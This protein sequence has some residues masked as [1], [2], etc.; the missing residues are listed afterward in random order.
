MATPSPAK[1][2][3]ND[4]CPCG[5]GKK[6]K[7]CCL[8]EQA[9]QYDLWSRQ[10][11]ASDALTRDMMKFAALH[12]G[13]ELEEAWKDFEMSDYPMPLEEHEDERQI[14]M[15]YFLFHWDPLRPRRRKAT[16]R[17]SG[18]VARAYALERGDQLS[19]LERLFLEQ[20][21]KK[22]VSFYEVL[23]N[24][25]GEQMEI[26]DVLIGGDVEVTERSASRTLQQGDMIYT[27]VWDLGTYSILGCMAPLGIPPKRKAEVIGLRR[28]LQRRIAKQ[29]RNLAAEDLVRFA[30]DIRETY[31]D[32]RDSLHTPPRFANTDGDPLHFHT[33]TFGIESEEAAF[34]ALAPLAVGRRKEELLE[35][36]ELD[37]AGKIRS[38]E[39]DWLKKGNRKMSTWENTILGSIRIAGHS[40]VAEVNSEK[41]AKRIRAEI[42]KRLGGT[43]THQ[44]TVAKTADE[45]LAESPKRGKD[46]AKIDEETV[47]DLLRDPEV[48][49]QLQV[50]IQKQVEAWAHEKVPAL[51]GRTPMQAVN[52]PEG[53]EIVESLLVQWERHEKEG[54]YDQRIQPD[55]GA[56]R[57]ILKLPASS[58]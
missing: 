48:R 32:L 8:A 36:A 30:D 14:F 43:T 34:E 50:E 1:I 49:K 57:R 20:A 55:I 47:D 51:G 58:D 15:P 5:S 17:N 53:R 41:R 35:E 54:M 16:Q 24:K 25:P 23:W 46:S 21:A 44:S 3:R 56:L 6:Y 11:E 29:K 31:L 7:R 38:V 2:G 4:P 45:M 22:P 52:D 12:F 39:F 9:A 19:E 26:W 37:K 28:K 18:M 13:E 10:R 27:Q 33:L 40:L 42:E